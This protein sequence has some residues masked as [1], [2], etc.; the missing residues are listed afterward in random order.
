MA[1]HIPRS[2]EI[3]SSPLLRTLHTQVLYLGKLNAI[4]TEILPAIKT[5][6]QVASYVN[7]VLT[8]QTHNTALL[9][10]LR[11]LQAHYLKQLQSHKVFSRL[12]RIQFMLSEDLQTP[13]TKRDAAKPL[14]ADTK[15]LIL[16]A[17]QSLS[18]VE[19]SEAL[20]RLA[21]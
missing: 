18:D 21:R 1:H 2:H 9:G 3:T 16:E 11:Y 20:Q 8:L 19:L 10:Q 7:G 6:C 15:K 4:V 5:Q 14:S 12:T 17:A 13:R